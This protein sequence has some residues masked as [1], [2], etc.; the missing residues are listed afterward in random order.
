MIKLSQKNLFGYWVPALP[1]K[2]KKALVQTY[3]LER[4]FYLFDEAAIAKAAPPSF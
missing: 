3:H 1:I 2:M 4:H